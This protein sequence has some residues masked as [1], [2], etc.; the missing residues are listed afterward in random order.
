MPDTDRPQLCL[1]TP[2]EID[3]D[4][5]CDAL[6]AVLDAVD[7]ACL[8]LSLATRDEDRIAR[9]ADAVRLVAHDRDIPVV[10]ESHVQIAERHGLD[11]V[12]LTDGA[13]S[14][15]TARKVLGT[16]AIVGAYCGQTRHEGINAGEAGADYVA[17]G[18]VGSVALGPGERADRDLFDW[19]SAMI[20][21]P[22][23]AEGGLTTELVESFAPVADFF[24]IGTEIWGADDPAAALKALMAPIL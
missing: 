5:F 7:T 3:L 14:V 10:I 2:A 4:T 20:E 8:R 13:R 18:P 16:D 12:H 21:V 11:G 15:R 19:W 6:S 17:F 1:I 23:I 22:V 24:A 9:A